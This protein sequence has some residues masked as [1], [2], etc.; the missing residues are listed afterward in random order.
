MWKN[1]TPMLL[2]SYKSSQAYALA[3]DTDKEIYIAGYEQWFDSRKP[4]IWKK[5]GNPYLQYPDRRGMIYDILIHEGKRYTAEGLY[6]PE[7]GAAI[8]DISSL[9]N[10]QITWLHKQDYI[11]AKA[12][13]AQGQDLYAVGWTYSGSISKTVLWKI[14]GGAVSERELG[15]TVSSPWSWFGICAKDSDI[16]VANKTLWKGPAARAR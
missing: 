14:A 8:V 16:Y 4:C 2:N 10:P 7:N 1:D 5:D 13:C 11:P 3:Q 15:T 9:D 12:L 6:S